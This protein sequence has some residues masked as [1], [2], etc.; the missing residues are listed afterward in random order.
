MTD[1]KVINAELELIQKAR[2]LKK[3]G[4]DLSLWMFFTEQKH[5]AKEQFW[6]TGLWFLGLSAGLIVAPFSF[7]LIEVG[8]SLKTIGT[9]TKFI[10][11][12]LFLLATLLAVLCIM[13]LFNM[14]EHLRRCMIRETLI[15]NPSI[16]QVAVKAYNPI[17]FRVLIFL[18]LLLITAGIAGFTSLFF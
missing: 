7:K 3:D 1:T 15:L 18:A 17:E 16:Q 4:N 14:R 5:K 2:G 8:E 10:V 6:K 11:I 13:V 12:V 9:F